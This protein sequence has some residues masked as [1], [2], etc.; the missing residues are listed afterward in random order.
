MCVAVS[1]SVIIPLAPSEDKPVTLINALP[2]E[3]E[4]ILAREA[5]RAQSLNAGAAKATGE[6]LW[7][8]HADSTLPA[9][10]WQKLQRA[11]AQ[12]PNALHYFNLGFA[13]G[14]WRMKLNSWGANLRS[15]YLGCPFGDQGFCIH[16]QLFQDLGT[17]SETAPYGEDHLFVWQAHKANVKLNQISATLTTSARK[18]QQR[19]WL[20]TTLRHGYLWLKQVVSVKWQQS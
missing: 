3:I 15:R 11:I 5:G 6:Y 18:Y 8:L 14:G 16:R 4:V 19:G 20:N 10:G 13:D 7:F 9:D 12:K 17:Y 2:P 1:L